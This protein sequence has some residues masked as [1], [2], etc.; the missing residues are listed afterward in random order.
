VNIGS[1]TKQPADVLDYDIDFSEW[2]RA[3][4]TLETIDVVLTRLDGATL[5]LDDLAV[6]YVINNTP[7]AKVWLEK[8]VDGQAYK[9]EVTVVT[10]EGRTK[11]VELRAR[12]RD[13]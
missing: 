6:K 2:L 3:G 9:A 12:V 7:I 13:Y 4:D 5:G 11:Q 10:R 1:I 8:G